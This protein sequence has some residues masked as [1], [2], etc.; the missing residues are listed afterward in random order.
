MHLHLE[1]EFTGNVYSHDDKMEF[2][3]NN[4]EARNDIFFSCA[5]SI[6]W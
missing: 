6:Y 2:Y 1:S 4:L 3:E 5:S